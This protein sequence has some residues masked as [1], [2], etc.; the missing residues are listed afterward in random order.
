MS[1]LNPVSLSL[2]LS[3]WLAPEEGPEELDQDC[4][5]GIAHVVVGINAHLTGR[6]G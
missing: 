2:S 1:P 6:L 3:P 4:D 5:D